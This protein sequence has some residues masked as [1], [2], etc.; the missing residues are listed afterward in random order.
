MLRDWQTA[1]K[2]CAA[3]SLGF[4]ISRTTRRWN[5]RYGSQCQLQRK[6]MS[7][8]TETGRETQ[9]TGTRRHGKMLARKDAPVFVLGCGRSGTTLLYHMLLS[10]GDFAV[11]RTES[12]AI[13]LLEPRFG[14]LS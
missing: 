9:S 13:N 4:Q 5:C 10:A 11:Y 2:K 6:S 12:N 7:E 14:D 8:I 3:G 1:L